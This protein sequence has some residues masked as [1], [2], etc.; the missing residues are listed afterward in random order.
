MQG[1]TGKEGHSWCI[2]NVARGLGAHPLK[3]GLESVGQGAA[4]P[5]HR[6]NEAPCIH[7]ENQYKNGEE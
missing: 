6:T 4:T 7:I 5:G 2:R 1:R 3:L